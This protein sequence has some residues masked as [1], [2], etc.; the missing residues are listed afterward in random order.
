MKCQPLS[1]PA[2]SLLFFKLDKFHQYNITSPS[3]MIVK[4]F[5]KLDKFHQYKYS[6]SYNY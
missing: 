1:I 4:I 2:L 5:F 6:L 3:R